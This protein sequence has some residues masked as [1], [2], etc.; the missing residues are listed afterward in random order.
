MTKYEEKLALDNKSQIELLTRL[1]NVEEMIENGESSKVLKEIVL[2][3]EDV[4]YS[5]IIDKLEI[6]K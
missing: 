5:A 6:F 2:L 3:A 4:R 1:W